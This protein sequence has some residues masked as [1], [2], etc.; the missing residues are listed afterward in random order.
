MQ[1]FLVFDFADKYEEATNDL[2][3]WIDSGQLKVL[4]DELE[5]LEKAPQGFVDLLAGG[6]IGTRIVNI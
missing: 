5:G 1:G 3:G 6:N 4:T 2:I